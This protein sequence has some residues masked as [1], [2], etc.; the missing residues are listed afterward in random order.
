MEGKTKEE[1]EVWF[2]SQGAFK[3]GGRRKKEERQGSEEKGRGRLQTFL[4]FFFFLDPSSSNEKHKV[5]RANAVAIEQGR[6]QNFA[7][8]ARLPLSESLLLGKDRE[9]EAGKQAYLLPRSTSL[10]DRPKGRKEEDK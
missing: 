9:R 4:L 5:L 3:S 7:F 10:S 1:R 2:K 8:A 6:A